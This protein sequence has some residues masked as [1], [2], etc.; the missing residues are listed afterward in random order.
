MRRA[1]A[2]R[3]G[4]VVLAALLA[5]CQNSGPHQQPTETVVTGT[6]TVV[7]TRT[8][9]PT[10]SNA[11]VRSVAPLPA[12]GSL[13][14]GEVKRSCP[15]IKAGLDS[16]P[17][18]GPN[19][20]DLEGDR[21]GTVTVL[22]QLNP[23][24]CRFYFAYS[25]GDTR[26]EAVADILPYTFATA[27]EARTAMVRTATAGKNLETQRNFVKGVDGIRYQTRFFGPDGDNDWAFVFAK[28]RHM[29]VVHTQQTNASYNAQALAEAIIA[30][31]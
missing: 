16:E 11:V 13:P 29:V 14:A 9:V 27:T 8:V 15:Y 24:G 26:H 19:V 25:Y 3:A 5:G 28:G 6:R 17:T 7:A 10:S 18:T 31:F 12:D 30:K 21:V 23:V 4:V 22:T 20:A 2:A 1:R